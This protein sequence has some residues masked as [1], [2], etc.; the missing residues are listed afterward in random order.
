MKSTKTYSDLLKDLFDQYSRHNG[1]EYVCWSD[2]AHTYRATNIKLAANNTSMPTLMLKQCDNDHD[3][4]LVLTAW[5]PYPGYNNILP[6]KIVA[7][8]L[9]TDITRPDELCHIFNSYIQFEICSSALNKVII[10]LFA[11][12]SVLIE[13]HYY[14]KPKV[15]R[16]KRI[17][18]TP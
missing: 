16:T 9:N 4:E 11:K 1:C 18:T 14:N 12:L 17:I 13:S 2:P 6:R 15:S 5:H 10:E 7:L 8:C 3:I